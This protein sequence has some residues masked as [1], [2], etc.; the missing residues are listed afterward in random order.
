MTRSTAISRAEKRK[1]AAEKKQK[2]LMVLAKMPQLNLFLSKTVFTWELSKI[3]RGN[4][5][6]F[7]RK[8]RAY[9]ATTE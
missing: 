1:A 9:V 7:E 6:S 2:D 3:L 8:L 4:F 5:D